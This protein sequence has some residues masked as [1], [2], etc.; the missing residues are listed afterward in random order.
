KNMLGKINDETLAQVPEKYSGVNGKWIGISA[1]TRVVV[2]NQAKI[3][4]DEL[5]ASVL[6]F[7]KPEWQ[8]RIGFVPT[9]G[10]FQEQ[11][12]AIIKLKGR[13]AAKKWLEGLKEY[14]ERYN[15]NMSAMKAVERGDISTALI[16]NYYWYIVAKEKGAENMDS[17][18]F[19]F[20]NPGAGSLITVSGGAI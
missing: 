18:L 7:A 19:Y 17:K 6:D 9:S 13:D 14:G 15:H 11:V 8:G 12:T 3:N 16:N 1:R 10:A 20:N 2:Y 5:P 4:E